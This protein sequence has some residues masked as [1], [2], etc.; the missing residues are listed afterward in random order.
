M[1]IELTYAC[2]MGC[3][4]CMSDCKPDG[5]H[6]TE[7]ILNDVFDFLKNH[8]ILQILSHPLSFSGGE[9][10]ENPDIL[11]LLDVI[12]ER[13]DKATPI[14]FITNG[15]QLVRN[16]ENYKKAE[17]LQKK[18]GK[19][20]IMIQVTD[21]PRFYPD[22][23]SE[24]EKYW[25]GKLNALIDTVPGDTHDSKKCLYPQGRALENYS[26]ES[27][28]TIGPKC[29]NSRLLP[30]QGVNSVAGIVTALSSAGRFCTP[31]IAPDGFI[32][33]GESA[34]C[35][36]VASIYDTDREIIEKIKKFQC[37]ACKI[38]FDRLKEMNPVAYDML[39]WSWLSE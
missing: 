32:K 31:V 2:S 18:Y 29:A 16:K 4:H 36:S 1:L 39:G 17:Q 28:N 10:F 38:P 33:L 30:L 12:E 27:W 26:D 35:P 25:L 11:R 13:W 24:K 22:K 3:T 8:N 6:M 37:H 34:L 5:Q 19:K 9:M 14:I 21:D 7:E 23:L 15:R 20:R